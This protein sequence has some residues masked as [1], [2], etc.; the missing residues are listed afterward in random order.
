MQY[1]SLWIKTSDKCIN[2]LF[3]IVQDYNY[4]RYWTYCSILFPHFF[5]GWQMTFSKSQKHGNLWHRH[6]MLTT[7]R[8]QT[9]STSVTATCT[10]LIEPQ[11]PQGLEIK[12]A[13][14]KHP[15]FFHTAN[16]EGLHKLFPW[17]PAF[18]DS[19]PWTVWHQTLW[20]W[21]CTVQL[22]CFKSWKWDCWSF[23]SEVLNTWRVAIF[24]IEREDGK[25]KP[26]PY[27][28]WQLTMM[29]KNDGGII[30]FSLT[31]SLYVFPV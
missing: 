2:D 10:W 1:K 4:K 3:A 15:Q 12:K 11:S 22:F 30:V 14:Q 13:K 16:L 25:K 5:A 28:A 31:H 27:S 19:L 24:N 8:R 26:H 23:K 29:H 21:T 18:G 7:P 6:I 17:Q 9:L 20:T